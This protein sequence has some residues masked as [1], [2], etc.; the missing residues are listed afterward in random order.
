MRKDGS[1][2]TKVTPDPILTL[3]GASPD[4]R[5]AVATM[6]VNEVP[7][8]AVFAMPVEGG[9]AQKICPATCMA[10]WSPDG[11]RFYVEPLLQGVKSGMT[12]AIPVP[13]GKSLPALPVSGIRTAQD[14]ATLPGS[15]VIDTSSFDPSHVGQ[16]IAPG[17]VADSFAYAKTIAH[18]NLFRIPIP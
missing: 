4:G 1:G 15:V 6:P 7:S 3:M 14:S 13:R 17:A 9:S 8:S 5:W 18:R 2:R 16:N 11:T 10:K 12:V